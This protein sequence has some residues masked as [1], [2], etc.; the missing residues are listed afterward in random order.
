MTPTCRNCGGTND[1]GSTICGPCFESLMSPPAEQQSGKETWGTA[2]EINF[3][4]RLA[5]NQPLAVKA[6]HPDAWPQYARIVLEGW[7]EYG[8]GV[9]VDRVRAEVRRL[10]GC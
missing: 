4:R 6:F 10:I 9:D 3:A 8:P 2:N 7:R 5:S 1:T